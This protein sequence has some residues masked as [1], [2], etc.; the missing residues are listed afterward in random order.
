MS[1]PVV[2]GLES[3]GFTLRGTLGFESSILKVLL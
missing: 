2:P 1:I 3:S